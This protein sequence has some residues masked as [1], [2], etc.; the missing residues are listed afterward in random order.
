ML[1]F[2]KYLQLKRAAEKLQQE[3]AQLRLQAQQEAAEYNEL[4]SQKEKLEAELNA[5]T[6]EQDSLYK[7][8]TSMETEYH[9]AKDGAQQSAALNK[10]I[11]DIGAR[12]DD[13]IRRAA[14]Y[15]DNI[16]TF[17]ENIELNVFLRRLPPISL[18][19]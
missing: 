19:K 1:G 11:A 4:V 5:C 7:Y 6:A 12:I 15:A 8:L 14:I 13:I 16:K 2:K 10:R 17:M 18:W 3:W 9:K